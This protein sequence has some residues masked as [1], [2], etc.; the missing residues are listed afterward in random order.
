LIRRV[1]FDGRDLI[2]GIPLY[3]LKMSLMG[4]FKDIFCF[5]ITISGLLKS[6]LISGMA[7]DGGGGTL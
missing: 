2:R 4:W 5:I 7:F 6:G 3:C 1:S